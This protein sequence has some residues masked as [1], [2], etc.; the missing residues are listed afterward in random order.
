MQNPPARER[1]RVITAFFYGFVLLLG[2][3]FLR[4]FEPFLVPLGWA[5]VLAVF[6]YPWHE[7]LVTRTGKAQAAAL[8]L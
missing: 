7:R 6:V 3:F 1:T 4:I 8:P 5:A 2:Y